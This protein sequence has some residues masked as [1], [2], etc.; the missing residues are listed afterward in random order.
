MHV[1]LHSHSAV[2]A[3]VLRELD[4]EDCSLDALLERSDF[5]SLH[6]PA[7]PETHH[8]IDA[9]QLERMAP[10]AILIN[11]ARGD[12]VDEAALAAALA[13][14]AI[15]GAGLDVYE[16][17]PV[18]HPELLRAPNAVLLPHLGSGSEETRVAMGLCAV[19]NLTAYFAG[20]E[21]PNPV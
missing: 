13:K 10:H 1:L 3:D 4:A 19:E 5:V 14:G 11:T 16:A 2:P 15:G 20:R 9:Q 21:L 6:C 17:E 18:V 7:T 12:V 8:L